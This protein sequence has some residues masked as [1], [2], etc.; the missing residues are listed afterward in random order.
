MKTFTD[1]AGREWEIS[2]TL[3]SMHGLKKL[4][5][6]PQNEHLDL[7]DP[8]AGKPALFLRLQSDDWLMIGVLQALLRKQM[9]AR[10]VDDESLIDA[11]DG[12]VYAA[13]YAA[14]F[15]EWSDFFLGRGQTNIC[16]AISKMEQVRAEARNQLQQKI[17]AADVTG[18][19]TGAMR[20][21]L[22]TTFGKP[23]DTSA[24]P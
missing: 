22:G 8:Q 2:L 6:G 4:E 23:P 15:Q 18:A 20:Q 3:G 10:G 19:V 17:E 7:L 16:A 14:F 13:A 11:I 1:T 9:A 12:A 21:I 5:V 24:S